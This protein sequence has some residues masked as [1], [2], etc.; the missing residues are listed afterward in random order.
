VSDDTIY[1]AFD[2]IAALGCLAGAAPLSQFAA[3]W[4]YQVDAQW[5]IAV[6]GHDVP[7]KTADD[8]QTVAPF[9]CYV[10]YN[11]WPAGSFNPYGGVIAAGSCANE[12]A[13]IAAL[14]AEIARLTAMQAVEQTI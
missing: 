14:D 9:E 5:R 12:D 13:F 2:K 4:E 3:C 10:E 8:V 1:E 7:K 6:N 11:G